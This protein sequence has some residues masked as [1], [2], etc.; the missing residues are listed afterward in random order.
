MAANGKPKRISSD[1]TVGLTPEL[2]AILQF[3]CENTM[4]PPSVYGRIAIAE[5][6][7]RDNWVSR[8]AAMI[9]N[10]N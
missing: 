2:H 7:S 4:L 10:A 8:A 5:K 6:L 1:L 9:K 3:A